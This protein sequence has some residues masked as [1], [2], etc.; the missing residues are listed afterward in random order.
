M[1][2]SAHRTGG[3]V[4]AWCTRC[5]MTL[6]HTIVALVSGRPARVQ[7]NTCG[8][9]HNYRAAPGE[10]AAREPAA[11][12][13]KKAATTRSTKVT[14]SFEEAIAQKSGAERTYSPKEAFEVDDVISHPTFGRGWV[15][16]V[17]PDKIEVVFRAGTRTLV[18]RR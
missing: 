11:A 12:A 3:E 8:G 4:D 10:A 7:C 1:S 5:R 2:V 9:N 15:N 18:H 17:R 16:A 14:Y 6:A 13:A